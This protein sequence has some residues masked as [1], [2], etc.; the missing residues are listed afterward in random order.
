MS[1]QFPPPASGDV[2]PPASAYPPPFPATPPVPPATPAWPAPAL[3]TADLLDSTA[4][5]AEPT[6]APRRRRGRTALVATLVVL[7]VLV[8]AGGAFGW[9]LLQRPDVRLA[10]AWSATT[11]AASGDVTVT[12]SGGSAAAGPSSV[13]YAWGPGTQQVQVKGADGI[14][15]VD[16]I[17]TSTHLTLQLSPT[18]LADQPEALDQLR[19][20]AATFGADG[21]ALD[22]LA[23][24]RPVGLEIGPGSPLQK[25]LG[26]LGA[27]TGGATP[28]SPVS[29]DNLAAL[30]STLQ[31]AIK[32]NVTVTEAGSD[33]YGDRTHLALPLAP[34]VRA[35]LTQAASSL[36]P[37]AGQV[38]RA[39][40]SS[41][42]G[43]TVQADVWTQD[44][45]VVR[46]AVPMSSIDPSSSGSVVAT[47][48]TTGVQQPAEP[49]TEVSGG[50]LD[51]LLGGLGSLGDLAGLGGGN[52]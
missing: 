14:D 8:G 29:S 1:Q 49:V 50:L 6:P 20:I 47:F 31:Q 26:E 38:S 40:L 28:S 11:S 24:G 35:V 34:V 19:T 43:R 51:K 7:L 5:P 10:R 23:A 37:L 36:G 52:G 32:D 25:L 3:G 21:A 46:V 9:S 17:L 2:P 45:R 44:G 15:L 13:R 12:A 41:I 22:A 39:D 27:S 33:Q 18:V 4:T 16:V 30:G 42:E 48:G